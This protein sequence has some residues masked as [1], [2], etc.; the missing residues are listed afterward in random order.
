[1][2]QFPRHKL[3]PDQLVSFS[4]LV[5]LY[6][7]MLDALVELVFL[8]FPTNFFCNF[9]FVSYCDHGLFIVS[10]F[11]GCRCCY[12]LM[13]CALCRV[14]KLCLHFVGNIADLWKTVCVSLARPVVCCGELSTPSADGDAP[15]E[16]RSFGIDDL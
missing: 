4:S 1:M 3:L 6:S 5:S 10:Y 11:R 13:S 7:F 16:S 15:M 9:P 12:C 8:F 14:G 2:L